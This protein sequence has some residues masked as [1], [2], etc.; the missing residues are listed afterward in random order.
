MR[1]LVRQEAE[2]IFSEKLKTIAERITRLEEDNQ[3]L[4]KE[5][6]FLKCLKKSPPHINKRNLNLSKTRKLGELESS[7]RQLFSSAKST[8]RNRGDLGAGI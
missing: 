6:S 7:S 1:E 4:K 2:D 5:I 8:S 3:L